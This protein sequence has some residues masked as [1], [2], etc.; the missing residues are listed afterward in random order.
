MTNTPMIKRALQFEL[1]AKTS[2]GLYEG[3]KVQTYSAQVCEH[4]L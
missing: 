2:L 1:G 3:Q 4:K